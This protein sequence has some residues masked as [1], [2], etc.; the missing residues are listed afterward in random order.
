MV[1]KDSKLVLPCVFVD[2]VLCSYRKTMRPCLMERCWK[3]RYFKRFNREMLGA[4]EKV[5]D[6]IEEEHRTG[7]LK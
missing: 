3:C 2:D 4:D 5:M 6:E 1:N 7:V